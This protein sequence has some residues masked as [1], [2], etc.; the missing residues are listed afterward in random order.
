MKQ[1]KFIFLFIAAFSML[2]TSCDNG[3]GTKYIYKNKVLVLNQGNFT[4]QDASVYM[5]DEDEKVMVPNAYARAN[6]NT[7]LGATLMSGTFSNYGVGYL[8]CSNPDK[9]EVINVVTLQ[10]LT[11]PITTNLANT[12]EIALGNKYLYVTNAGE[13]FVESP[14][15]MREYTN[16]YVSIYDLSNNSFV[17]KVDVGSDA[18]GVVFADGYAYVGTKA[19]IV[20][21][22]SG[23]SNFYAEEAYA[24]EE[25][26]GAVKYLCYYNNMIYASIPGYGIIEYDPSRGKTV[27]RYPMAES[28][29]YDGYFTMDRFG[30]IYTFSTDWANSSSV[31]YKLDVNTGNKSQIK[32]SDI[33]SGIGI[34]GYSGNIFTAETNGFMTNSTM[35]VNNT[36]NGTLVDTQIAGIGTFR[37]LSFS[38]LEEDT[39]EE[40]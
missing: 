7:K 14:D 17:A 11:E 39:S 3:L 30:Y 1:T 5:Y 10:T 19:G 22:S 9:I 34:S 29:N 12:R 16:S 15:K 33:I 20:K 23:G 13:D 25:Y 6:N 27:K 18:Q 2:L 32:E 36:Q 37:Y 40:K 8:L 38:Y 4:A 26:T 24:D 21:I 31:V 28:L 35:Y